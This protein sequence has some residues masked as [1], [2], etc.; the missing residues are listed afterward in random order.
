MRPG[1][2]LPL[3]LTA[4]V[5]A[6]GVGTYR[7]FNSEA[8]T[9]GTAHSG[10]PASAAHSEAWTVVGLVTVLAIAG[11]IL[12]VRWVLSRRLANSPSGNR[13]GFTQPDKY[14]RPTAVGR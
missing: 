2:L 14:S 11:L 12:G 7:L 3:V 6:F 4:T 1:K 5:V 10:S 13:P 8:A 9:S